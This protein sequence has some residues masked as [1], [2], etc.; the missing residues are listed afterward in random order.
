MQDRNSRPWQFL[1]SS[2]WL[3]PLEAADVPRLR[4]FLRR[5]DVLRAGNLAARL[6]P[7]DPEAMAMG[8]PAGISLVATDPFG[9]P[10]GVFHLAKIGPG[11]R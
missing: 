4:A 2:L 9:A 10:A 6:H 5:K 7:G 8:S 3:R 11:R 1:G